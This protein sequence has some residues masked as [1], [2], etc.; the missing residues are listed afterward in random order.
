MKPVLYLTGNP[1]QRKAY[2]HLSAYLAK[3]GVNEFGVSDN[4]NSYLHLVEGVEGEIY[5]RINL[6][7]IN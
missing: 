2:C 3:I 6:F 5:D 7:N 1:W 4:G